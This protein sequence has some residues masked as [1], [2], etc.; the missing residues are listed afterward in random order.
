M[1]QKKIVEKF[2][3]SDIGL[4][5]LKCDE[6]RDASN[7]EVMSVCLRFVCDGK[8]IEHLLS[9]VKLDA[10]DAKSIT[11]EIIRELKARNVDPQNIL[12]TCFDGAAV[13]SGCFGGVQKLLS[14]ELK[15]SIP[16]VHCYNHRLHLV[17]VHSIHRVSQAKQFF[18]TCE[19]L[20]VFFRCQ[21]LST[22]Y[23]GHTL[24]RVLEQRWTGHLQSAKVILENRSEILAA[25]DDASDACIELS[26]EAAG[27]RVHVLKP[28]FAFI[29][30]IVVKILTVL[31]P[32]NAML[33]SKTVNVSDA[34]DMI[35]SSIEKLEELRSDEMF[36][37]LAKDAGKFALLL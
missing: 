23:H 6:T 25:L 26:V 35:R 8:P 36:Y 22:A 10:V 3:K 24:K 32:A 18:S 13:M 12:S 17:V 4:S 5:C 27:L 15:L 34:A 30:T 28:Q 29:A 11:G 31:Q 7:V 16:Y 19:Q 21:F 37:S 1:V 9:I 2:H 20:Y 33:Q 14:D